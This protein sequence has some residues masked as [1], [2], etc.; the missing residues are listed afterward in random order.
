VSELLDALDDALVDHSCSHTLRVHT[1][2][3]GVFS[4]YACDGCVE[5]VQRIALRHLP[6]ATDITVVARYREARR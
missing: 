5:T 2:I 6:T 3:P 1:L 4:S